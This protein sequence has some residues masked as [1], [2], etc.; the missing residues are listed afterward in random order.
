MIAAVAIATNLGIICMALGAVCGKAKNLYVA[1]CI[2][3]HRLVAFC[4]DADLSL[5]HRAE[6]R[7]EFVLA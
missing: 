3:M 4:R 1:N 6:I 5:C 7:T 2:D